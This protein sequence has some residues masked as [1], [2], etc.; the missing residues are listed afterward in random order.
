M[1]SAGKQISFSSVCAGYR[2]I[3]VL[4]E[5]NLELSTGFTVL[6]GPNGCGKTTLFRTGCGILEPT[7]GE[8]RING[9]NPYTEPSIKREVSYLPHKPVL[10]PDLTVQ[11]NFRFWARIHDL[12]P[13]QIDDRLHMLAQRFEFADLLDRKG[14]E[15]SR[16]QRQRASIGQALISDPDVLFLDEATSGLDPMIARDIR[17]YLNQLGDE[18]I[19]LYSTHNLN[20]ADELADRLVIMRDGRL[21][22]DS[23]MSE[24]RDRYLEDS[25]VGFRTDDDARSVLESKGYDPEQ[26][27][28]YWVI[29]MAEDE[30]PGDLATELTQSGINVKEIKRMGNEIEALYE[31]SEIKQ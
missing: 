26:V 14:N 1:K 11:E 6:L 12:D 31:K 24:V 27:G 2:A 5:I 30:V 10:N 8:V 20:E 25:R 23:Q 3:N 9:E 15:L 22:L 18:R 13:D 28:Q 17:S 29:E 19:V 16:G 7:R 4:D 21:V